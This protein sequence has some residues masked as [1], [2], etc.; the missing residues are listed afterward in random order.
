[1]AELFAMK[2]PSGQ[3]DPAKLKYPVLVQP[4]LDGLRGICIK[5][6]AHIGASGPVGCRWFS[7]TGKPLW[8]LEHVSASLPDGDVGVY[9]G[10]IIWPGHPFSDAYGLCKRQTSNAETRKQAKELEFHC[11]DRL[12]LDEWSGK[13]TFRTF[14]DR[15]N[16][17]R[18]VSPASKIGPNLVLM[19]VLRVVDR[20]GLEA[21]YQEFLDAGHEGLMAKAINGLYHWT[22]HPD[23]HR[24]KPTITVD[25]RVVGTYEEF[26]KHGVAKGT[27]G[28]VLIKVPSENDPALEVLCKCGNGFKATE[29]KKWWAPVGKP[30]KWPGLGNLAVYPTG[31][32]MGQWIEV[33]SKCRNESGAL[34]EP[35][36]KRLRE[37]KS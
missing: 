17:L 3:L 14:A 34:R 37:D 21:A 22:R 29:R 16:K 9:D 13:H 30:Q 12:E 23:W 25:A 35:H 24:Y 26:D 31:P 1:M 36:F 6:G 15:V 32:L 8:N 28:G 33:E 11:F 10:E 4:K 2:T 5:D 18:E 7:F 19:D 27:L 20:E